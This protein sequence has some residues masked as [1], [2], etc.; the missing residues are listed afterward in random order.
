MGHI[1]GHRYKWLHFLSGLF[2]CLCW[3]CSRLKLRQSVEQKP[4][5]NCQSIEWEYRIAW[6]SGCNSRP[7]I[8]RWTARHWNWSLCSTSMHQDV[9]SFNLMQTCNQEKDEGEDLMYKLNERVFYGS[10]SFL[11][12]FQLSRFGI[13]RWLNKI[14]SAALRIMDYSDMQT[15]DGIRSKLKAGD[16]AVDVGANGGKMIKSS[17][18]TGCRLKPLPTAV[19]WAI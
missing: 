17:S 4:T 6:A 7:T 12:V 10:K 15:R 8:F 14:A 3:R 9:W 2:L 16:V 13:F 11:K 1:L 19:W 5:C 18:T